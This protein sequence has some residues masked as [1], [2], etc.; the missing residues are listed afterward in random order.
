[1]EE[2]TYPTSADAKKAGNYSRRHKTGDARQQT[3]E[4]R[5]IDRTDK[6]EGARARGANAAARTP[7]QQLA[8]LDARLGSGVGAKK[9]RARL[10]EQIVA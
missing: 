9:E 1:M 5:A 8:R 7:E 10:Q 2:R 6:L 3:R 4:G